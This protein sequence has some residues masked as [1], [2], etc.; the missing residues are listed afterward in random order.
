VEGVAV[1][2]WGQ[3][4]FNDLLAD[5]ESTGTRE[6]LVMSHVKFGEISPVS[7]IVF[8]SSTPRGAKEAA[9]CSFGRHEM[10]STRENPW[11]ISSP[12]NFLTRSLPVG[13]VADL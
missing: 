6:S 8:S 10:G 12:M 2:A 9:C 1:E 5:G 3:F 11:V 4:G 13:T 7:L